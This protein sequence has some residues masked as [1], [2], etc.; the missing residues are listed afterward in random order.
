MWPER[1]MQ[2]RAYR[3]PLGGMCLI[4]RWL[5]V[6]PTDVWFCHLHVEEASV[7]L[8]THDPRVYLPIRIPT[9]SG[10]KYS[11]LLKY[12]LSP[13]L[14]INQVPLTYGRVDRY[15]YD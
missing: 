6:A 4:E 1:S 8:Q 9:K 13:H 2:C 5:N 3:E 11:V 12:T 14:P 15:V 10:K 7:Y